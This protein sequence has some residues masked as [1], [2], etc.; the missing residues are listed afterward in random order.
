MFKKK[1]VFRHENGEFEAYC[2]PMFIRQAAAVA[3]SENQA[4]F[5]EIADSK[6]GVTEMVCVYRS[7]NPNG[8]F[9]FLFPDDEP[10]N[11]D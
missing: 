7:T 3:L 11:E 5:M 2:N 8:G 4:K 10:K 9:M 1:F 6:T